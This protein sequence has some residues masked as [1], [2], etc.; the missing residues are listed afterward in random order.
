MIDVR[1]LG[2]TKSYNGHAVLEAID[3]EVE[4]GQFVVVL[5]RSGTGKSTL[6]NLIGCLD[7]ASQ[8]EIQLLGTS[9]ERLDETQR[10]GLRA[11]KLGFV[12]QFFN[13]IPTLTARENI[14]LPLAINR[15]SKPD[16]RA[17]SRELLS[18]LGLEHCANRFP[19]ELSGGEQQRVAIARAIAHEPAIVLA[20]EPTGNLDL[21]TGRT[22][23]DLLEQLCRSRGTTL[24]MATHSD[25]VLGRANRVVTINNARLIEAPR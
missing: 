15:V 17:R 24:I 10:A 3:F 7:D 21:E 13:L 12:F 25:E 9:I 1:L 23:L 8:G 5:G 2:V 20:D 22:V 19:D 14:E 16:L 11:R 4:H 18:E 6:L